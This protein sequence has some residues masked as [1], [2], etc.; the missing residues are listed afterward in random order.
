MAS[1]GLEEKGK[2]RQNQWNQIPALSVCGWVTCFLCM[3]LVHWCR[4]QRTRTPT[5]VPLR[6]LLLKSLQMY[7]EKRLSDKAGT[8]E[9]MQLPQQSCGSVTSSW[10][11][12]REPKQLKLR[13]EVPEQQWSGPD[14]GLPQWLQEVEGTHLRTEHVH[15][16][17]RTVLGP[18]HRATEHPN[19][20]RKNQYW[21]F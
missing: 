7:T 19:R 17:T 14:R 9:E 12:S 8:G 10:T 2:K 11:P 15:C 4:T 13:P 18:L 16:H 21:L 20:A 1:P 3:L 5:P 6:H